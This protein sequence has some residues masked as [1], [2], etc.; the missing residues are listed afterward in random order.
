MLAQCGSRFRLPGILSRIVHSGIESARRTSGAITAGIGHVAHA[1]VVGHTEVANTRSDL[2][3]NASNL[4]AWDEGIFGCEPIVT[5]LMYIRV[6]DATIVD[7][8]YDIVR[9]RGPTFQRK[10]F[11]R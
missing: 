9:S 2:F 7:A 4:M 3:D 11:K 1:H 8:D 10:Q 6:T 5:R